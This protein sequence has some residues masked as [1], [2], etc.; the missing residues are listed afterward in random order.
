VARIYLGLG[1]NA[2]AERNLR[3]AVRELRRRF[4]DLEL[5]PVYQSPPLG[6]EG[7]DFLNAVAGLDTDLP[8]RELLRQLEEIHVIAGRRRD[9]QKLVSRTLDI[10]LL[11]YDQLVVDEPGLRL[12]RSDVLEYSFVLRPL[13]ELA[14]GTVHPVTRRSM[15]EHWRDFEVCEA[16]SHAG[17]HPLTAVAID[18]RDTR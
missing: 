14:P 18:L 10:D 8:P 17:R 12:P 16:G 9:A 5:S 7:D 15:A 3:L 4:G 2:D 6:F 11:L 13:A 1:S